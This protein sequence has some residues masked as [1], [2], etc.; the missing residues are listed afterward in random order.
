MATGISF[1]GPTL[2]IW[3]QQLC[4]GGCNNF[5]SNTFA[6][7]SRALI[8]L[9]LK[10]SSDVSPDTTAAQ[11]EES[12]T[13]I[14]A[15]AG[16]SSLISALNVERALRG[17]PI[18]DIDHYGRLGI[19]RGCSYEQVTVAYRNKVEELLNQEGLDEDQVREKMGFLKESYAILSSP[20]ERRMYD[21]S[22]GRSEKPDRYGW[23]YQSDILKR[24]PDSEIPPFQDVENVGPTRLVGYFFLV[25]IVFSFVL[26]IALNL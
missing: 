4:V 19:Q 2:S 8:F 7:K 1:R 26:S 24:T 15:P 10:S 5:H 12:Q 21:W 3:Q 22:L 14:E 11:E 20:E 16:T 25:W 13:Y 23:P 18:T 17:I 9:P 6:P